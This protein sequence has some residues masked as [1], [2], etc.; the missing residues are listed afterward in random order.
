MK[1]VEL[2][3]EIVQAMVDVPEDVECFESRGGRTCVIEVNVNT[4]DVGKVI[5]KH[6]ANADAIRRLLTA[7]GGKEGIAYHL[8]VAEDRGGIVR[9]S[10]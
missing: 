2:I 10:V 4:I 3:Q 1:V 8:E 5:G 9:R 6:G 7:M